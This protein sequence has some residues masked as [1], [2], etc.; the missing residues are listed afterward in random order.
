MLYLQLYLP[1][2]TPLDVQ[3]ETRWV[4][5]L[6]SISLTKAENSLLTRGPNFAIVSKYSPKGEYI[7]I[8]KKSCLKSP[9]SQQQNSGL[10]LG[11]Y[12]KGTPPRPNITEEETRALKELREEQSRVILIVD[13][14]KAMVVQDKQDYINMAQ[15]L[16][17]DFKLPRI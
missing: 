8:V 17:N 13:K 7:A 6:S 12:S 16:P 9:P 14:G 2:I 3:R 15:D 4:I 11:I 5:S 1:Q 10:K